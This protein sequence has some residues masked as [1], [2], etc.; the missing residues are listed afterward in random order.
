MTYAPQFVLSGERY[1]LNFGQDIVVLNIW[2]ADGKGGRQYSRRKCPADD[3]VL[4]LLRR[5]TAE[6]TLRR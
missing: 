2:Q 1:S 5:R 6:R 4:A 3:E